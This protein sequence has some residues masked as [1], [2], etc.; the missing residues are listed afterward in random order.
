MKNKIPQEA[1][2]LFIEQKEKEIKVTESLKLAITSG[3]IPI[4][5]EERDETLASLDEELEKMHG[6]LRRLQDE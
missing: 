6:H 4:P 3:I 5:D 2:N 1:I